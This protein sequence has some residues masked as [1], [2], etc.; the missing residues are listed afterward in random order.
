MWASKVSVV[1]LLVGN[2]RQTPLAVVVQPMA[3]VG[4]REEPVTVVDFGESF[5][6]FCVLLGLADQGM[7]GLS[8]ADECIFRY[9][10]RISEKNCD[11]VALITCIEWLLFP[12]FWWNVRLVDFHVSR[13]EKRRAYTWLQYIACSLIPYRCFVRNCS[14]A[15]DGGP[16][17][18]Q[19]CRAYINSFVKFTKN[20]EKVC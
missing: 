18:C 2:G 16:L 6:I 8:Q 5:L 4:P 20:G 14:L 12:C 13:R 10:M 19:K 3:I 11:A 9:F 7:N 15:G 17:R 1:V